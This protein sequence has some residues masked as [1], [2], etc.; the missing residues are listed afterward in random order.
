MKVVTLTLPFYLSIP[1]YPSPCVRLLCHIHHRAGCFLFLNSDIHQY[2]PQ[3]GPQTT[4][5]SVTGSQILKHWVF[6]EQ[7]LWCFSPW[8]KCQKLRS[9]TQKSCFIILVL[10]DILGRI[11]LIHT[12]YTNSHG[13]F[14]SE[15]KNNACQASFTVSL[16]SP[17]SSVS[18]Y[19]NVK[20]RN[21]QQ[22]KKGEKSML[23]YPAH[24]VKTKIFNASFLFCCESASR[25]DLFDDCFWILEQ[26][27]ASPAAWGRSLLY[28]H[29]GP[30]ECQCFLSL[31]RFLSQTVC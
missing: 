14:I 7:Q 9:L 21:K 19:L 8:T 20:I 12:T 22:G 4:S 1:T 29:A 18:L 28:S 15:V 30:G 31:L 13:N 27:I 5:V 16:Q 23:V 17:K 11:S 6:L 25:R 26:L 2:S 24:R 10:T 3:T